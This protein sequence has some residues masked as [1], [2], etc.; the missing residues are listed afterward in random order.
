MNILKEV[1]FKEGYGSPDELIRDWA[2]IMSLSKLEQY[3]AENDF[4]K[5]KYGMDLEEFETFLHKEKGSEDFKKE[6][7][8]E[9]WE[10]SFNALKWWE[11]KVRELQHASS[12]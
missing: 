11:E 7:D 3:K 8:I 9:D 12:S 6:E 4:F 1:L 10:F 2:F 5:N